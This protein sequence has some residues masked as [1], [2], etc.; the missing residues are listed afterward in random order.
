MALN[1]LASSL[2]LNSEEAFLLCIITLHFLPA[3]TKLIISFR[4]ILQFCDMSQQEIVITVFLLLWLFSRKDRMFCLKRKL[5][6][7]IIPEYKY[8]PGSGR[9]VKYKQ[10]LA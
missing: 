1:K 4:S 10:Q 7:Q 8:V 2:L 5:F 3:L 6:S 9:T